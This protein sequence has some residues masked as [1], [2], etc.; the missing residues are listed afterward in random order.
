M[1]NESLIC[2]PAADGTPVWVPLSTCVW[3]GEKWFRAVTGLRHLYP[4]CE[5]LFTRHLRCER[6]DIRHLLMEL[7]AIPPS[8]DV[9]YIS[10][11]LTLFQSLHSDGRHAVSRND[12]HE[13][14]SIAMFPITTKAQDTKSNAG[15]N[16]DG[17]ERLASLEDP[18]WFVADKAQVK[19]A[20]AGQLPM[21]AFDVA[22]AS[23]LTPLFKLLGMRSRLLSDVSTRVAKTEGSIVEGVNLAMFY[24]SRGAFIQRCVYVV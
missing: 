11:V 12:I 17:Y 3:D 9:N 24:R 15:T 13:C 14:Q 2:R 20:F 23:E 22:K 10:V 16:G 8:C 7:H 1:S 21:L 18:D 5:T 19:S 4:D 6:L